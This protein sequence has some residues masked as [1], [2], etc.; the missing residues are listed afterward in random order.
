MKKYFILIVMVLI[1]SYTNYAQ[2]LKFDGTFI[3]AGLCGSWG[4]KEWGKEFEVM[5]ESGMHYLVIGAVAESYK[6]DPD[7]NHT[8]YPSELPGT[9]MNRRLNGKDMVDVCL[10]NAE[11]YGIKVFIGIGMSDKWWDAPGIDSTWLYDRMEFDN[12]VLD[13]VWDKY[14][15]KY[16]NAFYGWYWVYEVANIDLTDA[17]VDV[18]VKA[19]NIQLDHI[20]AT[21][22][23]LPFMWCP[24]M[25]TNYGNAEQYGKM[26]EYV[27][28]R[29][30]TSNGD[31]FAPQDCV[32]AGGLKIDQVDEWFKVLK[33]AVDT[34][35]G[36]VMWSD[37]ETFDQTDW[38]SAT[39]D[40][41]IKQ[42]EIEKP[43][44]ENYI[45][46]AY[47]HY[48]SPNNCDPGFHKTYMDYLK[49]GKV[50]KTPPTSPENLSA[51]VKGDSVVISWIPAS[52]NIG[53]CGYYIYRDDK[54]ILRKQFKQP[55]S[56]ISVSDKEIK[57]GETYTYKVQAYDFANNIS[58]AVTTNLKI[59]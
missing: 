29:I 36:L 22:K 52:D 2:E 5:K 50:E 10:R 35:P 57:A 33:K 23:K 26:W 24:F 45:T 1:L 19:M 12:K 43:Y 39:I 34:K 7:V 42:M 9:K 49:N 27:F 40:R 21:G 59:K 58:K 46:F 37:V 18:L 30:H 55:V 3:Q 20:N 17:Q 38:S 16:P 51:A 8:L 54:L 44:V 53:V 13:E 48:N 32:G 14:K 56:S 6:R 25:N 31:I 11:K 28:A 47:S 4:D 15:D 41:V